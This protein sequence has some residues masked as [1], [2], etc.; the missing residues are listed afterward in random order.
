MRPPPRPAPPAEA[1]FA[2]A[3]KK[4]IPFDFVLHELEGLAPTTK[5]M[6]GCTAVYVRDQI[7]FVLRDRPSSPGDNGVWVATTSEHH[8]SLRGEFESLRSIGVLGPGETGWQCLPATSA[9]FEDDV[10][11]ACALVRAGDR[12][13]GKVPARR[14][15]R[16]GAARPGGEATGA[17]G[18]RAAGLAKKA[19]GAKQAAGPAKK[20]TGAKQAARPAKQAVGAKK[21][22]RPGAGPP[23]TPAATKRSPAPGPRARRP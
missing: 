22:A 14:T 4:A 18:D 8:A 12:R 11:R 6:F 5:P 23:A 19:T 15:P 21:A 9:S 10:L 13:I 20:A 1:L 7:V 3:G 2:V 16:G 17:K